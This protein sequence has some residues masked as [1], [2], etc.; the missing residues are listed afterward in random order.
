MAVESTEDLASFFETE[1]FAVA[2]E[3]APVSGDAPVSVRGILTRHSSQEAL[4][5]MQIGTDE[6][7]F[8]APRAVF[9]CRPRKGDQIYCPATGATFRVRE[10][11]T[12]AMGDIYELALSA[13]K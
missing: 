10:T 9:L 1:E 12:G 11:P 4:G 5:A 8:T 13:V 2:V 3:Y 7:V 6:A